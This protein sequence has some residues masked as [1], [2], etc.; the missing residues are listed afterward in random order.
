MGT[1]DDDFVEETKSFCSVP[2]VLLPV[3]E[4]ACEAHELLAVHA[5]HEV[6]QGGRKL[7]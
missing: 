7:R 5:I 6:G 2:N 3:R 1:C 4:F